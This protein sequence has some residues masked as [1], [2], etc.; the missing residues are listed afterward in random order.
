MQVIPLQAAACAT[1]SAR[2]LFFSWRCALFI[3]STMMSKHLFR[4]FNSSSA[5]S[6]ILEP[7]VYSTV[8][9]QTPGTNT[10]TGAAHTQSHP[11]FAAFRVVYQRKHMFAPI[12]WTVTRTTVIRFESIAIAHWCPVLTLDTMI[13][14]S[15]KALRYKLQFETRLNIV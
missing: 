14:C 8:C 13:N 2:T 1:T 9:T 15:R 10:H 4:R 5:N 6:A 3:N 12:P 11:S 7:L